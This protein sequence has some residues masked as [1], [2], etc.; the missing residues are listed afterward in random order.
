[1]GENS[2]I[3]LCR[4]S[5]IKKKNLKKIK[6]MYWQGKWTRLLY[7]QDKRNKEKPKWQKSK[8]KFTDL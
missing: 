1:M 7:N 5:E 3:Q 2:I 6:I 8:K 4:Y